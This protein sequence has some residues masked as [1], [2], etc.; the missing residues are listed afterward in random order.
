MNDSNDIPIGDEPIIQ[1]DLTLDKAEDEVKANLI[2]SEKDA[3][4]VDKSP[5]TTK[6]RVLLVQ[7]EQDIEDSLA[8][9]YTVGR[10]LYEIKTKKLYRETHDSFPDYCQERFGF[11][12]HYANRVIQAAGTVDNL[13]AVTIGTTSIPTNEAQARTLNG[14][15]PKEQ[16]QVAAQVKSNV[17]DREPTTEDFEQ[18]KQEVTG[19]TRTKKSAKSNGKKKNRV[20]SKILPLPM[21]AQEKVRLQSPAEFHKGIK[22]PSL[23]E[24]SDKAT[25]LSNIGWNSSRKK[26]TDKL[27]RELTH[28]LP[29]Y[30][31][32]EQASI[33]ADQQQEAA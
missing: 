18:A 13:K 24:L 23:R 15:E 10:R 4:Q 28:W 33:G 30:A 9:F 3:N 7:C 14:L 2:L 21:N 32:W 5:L 12:K 17:G 11:G 19:R 22:L 20:D 16:V 31:E 27:I 6:D 1:F 8:S 25:T 29:L 26:E